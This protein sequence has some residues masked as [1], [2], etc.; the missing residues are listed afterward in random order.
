M[1]AGTKILREVHDAI[2]TKN[3]GDLTKSIAEKMEFNRRF[4]LILAQVHG[5]EMIKTISY[6]ENGIIKGKN[7]TELIIENKKEASG[8]DASF[9]RDFQDIGLEI[10]KVGRTSVYGNRSFTDFGDV[11]LT[12][13]EKNSLFELGELIRK[14][15]LSWY[16]S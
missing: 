14:Q 10:Y 13:T 12:S 6:S 4:P 16:C 3:D 2:D 5:T 1:D 15:L 9:Q 8:K 7:Q 11:P